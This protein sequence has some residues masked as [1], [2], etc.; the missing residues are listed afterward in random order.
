MA[1][2]VIAVKVFMVMMMMNRLWPIP[3]I[4][5]IIISAM[6]LMVII[7]ATVFMAFMV[8]VFAVIVL[9]II[10]QRYARAEKDKKSCEYKHFHNVGLHAVLPYWLNFALIGRSLPWGGLHTASFVR[11][12]IL[13]EI[14]VTV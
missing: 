10:C 6:M 11:K 14:P 13:M 8:P 5:P 1:V 2:V 4:V 7:V 9:T 12:T 3:T